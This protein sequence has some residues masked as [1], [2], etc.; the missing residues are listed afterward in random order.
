MCSF[1]NEEGKFYSMYFV[2]C[3]LDIPPVSHTETS[4]TSG[5]YHLPSTESAP[6]AGSLTMFHGSSI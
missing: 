1:S 3:H 2:G 5:A 4:I 6:L